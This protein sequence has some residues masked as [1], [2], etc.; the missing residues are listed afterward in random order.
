[1]GPYLLRRLL[2]VPPVLLGIATLT[3]LALHAIPGDLAA[4]LLELEGRPEEVARLREAL[5]L[6]RPLAVRYLEWLGRLVRADLGNSTALG[7]PV[8]RLLAARLPVT[9]SLALT[10]M[11]IA[12]SLGVSLGILAAGRQ[13]SFLDL[14]LLAG[15]QVGLAI[16]SFLLGT[17]LL[18]AFAAAVPAF[19]LQGYVPFV[20][21]PLE[22][23]RHLAL[24]ALTL[25]LDR[26]AVLI[27]IVRASVLEELHQDYVRTAYGKGLPEAAILRRHVLP[28]ALIPVLTVAGMQLGYLFGGALVV[29]QV[30][31]LPGLGRLAVQGIYARDA[32]VVEGAVLTLALLLVLL[33]L[34]V[35]LLYAALDPRIT[36]ET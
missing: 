7:E 12:L 28:N 25:G 17:L 18:L 9:I 35:D 30:F 8:V 36:Y 26:A 14:L 1:M 11:A 4:V 13:G 32:A 3:F 33:N 23:A 5:G 15:S 34:A 24:P 10:S 16:P 2:S 29:E 27:R 31:G 22:W 21:S 19:P 20:H 6:H